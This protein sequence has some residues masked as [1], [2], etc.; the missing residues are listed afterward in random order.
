MIPADQYTLYDAKKF[1]DI[2]VLIGYNS[3]E[4]ASF[5][6]ESSPKAYID[7]VRKRYGA[8]ADSLL[9]AYPAGEKTVPKTARDL[10]RDA[11]FGWQTWIWARL[12][13]QRGKSKVFYLLLRSAS[14]IPPLAQSMRLWR[15]ARPRGSLCLRP[16]ERPAPRKFPAPPTMSSPTPW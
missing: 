16:S 12:Q 7:G 3:D 4:G 5:S 11:A 1:N 15:V 13:S 9:K 6:H 14:R 8:F 10:A 2:P